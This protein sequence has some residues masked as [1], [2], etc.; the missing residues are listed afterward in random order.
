MQ[1][2]SYIDG[3]HKKRKQ[4]TVVEFGSDPI[5]IERRGRMLDADWIWA[6]ADGARNSARRPY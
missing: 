2:T 3:V 1:R 4:T 5:S 6:G